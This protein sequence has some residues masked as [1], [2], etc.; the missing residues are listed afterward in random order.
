MEAQWRIICTDLR[1]RIIDGEWEIGDRLPPIKVLQAEYDAQSLNTVRAAQQALVDEGL[2]ETHQGRGAF[3]VSLTPLQRP[4]HEHDASIDRGVA[5]GLRIEFYDPAGQIC[6][7]ALREDV[8]GA[9][10]P[11][12]GDRLGPTSLGAAVHDVAGLY[13]DVAAV[14]HYLLIGQR[15]EAPLA[16]VIARV[17]ATPTGQDLLALEADGWS[18]SRDLAPAVGTGATIGGRR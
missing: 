17:D 15:A 9:G 7:A 5:L 3:V 8:R 12:V 11:Q 1:R 14:E 2:L 10:V 18:V 16:V 6:A 13:V 4:R